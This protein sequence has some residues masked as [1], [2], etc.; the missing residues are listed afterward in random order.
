MVKKNFLSIFL[1]LCLDIYLK[2]N[3]FYKR[4]G[5]MFIFSLFFINCEFNF[6]FV[7]L[8]LLFLYLRRYKVRLLVKIVILLDMC[9]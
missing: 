8:G 2:L 3:I 1:I 4:K 6:L 7:F 9:L 5:N